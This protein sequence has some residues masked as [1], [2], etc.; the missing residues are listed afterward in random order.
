MID[1]LARHE[2]CHHIEGSIGAP[3]TGG[4]VDATDFNLVPVFSTDP[5][6]KGESAGG[7]LG[8][9]ANLA[10]HGDWVTQCEQVN[11]GVDTELIMQV[12]NSGGLHHA[13]L[14]ASVVK[15]HMVSEEDMV[16]ACL[17]DAINGDPT[18]GQRLSPNPQAGRDADSNRGKHH[19]SRDAANFVAA[20][21]SHAKTG[22]VARV[23]IISGCHCTAM[24]GSDLCSRPSTVPSSERAVTR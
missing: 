7:H 22:S 10:S 4:R 14:A 15:A 12:G 18:L 5:D 9:V 2:P 19:A 11:P 17:G 1:G 13:V 20:S 8:H 24:I 23:C 6:T 16:D 3:T 21:T